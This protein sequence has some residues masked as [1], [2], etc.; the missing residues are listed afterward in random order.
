M[1]GTVAPGAPPRAAGIPAVS[2]AMRLVA[3][4]SLLNVPLNL[5]Y[6]SA[7]IPYYETQAVG[8]A[9]EALFF[10]GPWMVVSPTNLWGIDPGDPGHYMAVVNFLLPN[11]ALSGMDSSHYDFNAGFGQQLWGLVAAELPVSAECAALSCTPMVP[12]SPITGMTGIDQEIW[13]VLIWTGQEHLP[14]LASWFK[15][16][17]SDITGGNGYTF[18]PDYPGYADPS[19]PAFSM[20]GDA[21]E[22]THEVDGQNLMPFAG[23][24]YQ[25]DPLAP[26]DNFWNQLIAPPSNDG[27]LGTGVLL[28]SL[29]DLGR[30]LQALAAATVMAFDP[31]TPGS[32]FCPLD[33]SYL[34]ASLNY[35]ALVKDI[36]ALWPNNPIIDTWLTHLQD[37]TANVP[38]EQEIETSIR[39]LQQGPWD[40]GNPSPPNAW[41]PSWWP[42]INDLSPAFHQFWTD[43]GVLVDIPNVP[44]HGTGDFGLAEFLPAL[45]QV[46]SWFGLGPLASSAAAEAV[47]PAWLAGF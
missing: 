39:I 7:N 17:F 15:V 43:Y 22:G 21:F 37:G 16:P 24:T 3:D 4:D 27:V 6:D 28:P 40:F 12:T 41:S 23:L 31:V 44:Y 25:L 11:P 14:I 30:N 1:A 5:F 20:Y 29:T 34:P 42:E 9:A 26:L 8:F 35:P 36:G 2:P 13:S 38:T 19:G 46:E 33:C 10:S 45:H 18:G 47:D 32:P